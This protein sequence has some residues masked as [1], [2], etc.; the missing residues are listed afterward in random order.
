MHYEK[1][2]YLGF[3]YIR[4][5]IP[6]IEVLGGRLVERAKAFINVILEGN[7]NQ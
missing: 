6:Q 7:Y 4:K 1:G 3:T 2:N 5:K